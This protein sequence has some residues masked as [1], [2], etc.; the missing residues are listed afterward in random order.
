MGLE[1]TV[2]LEWSF[3]GRRLSKPKIS[4]ELALETFRRTDLECL[5]I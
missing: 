3:Q 4:V 1:L 2:Q 5:N